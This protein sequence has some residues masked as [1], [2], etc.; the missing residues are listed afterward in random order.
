[1]LD[2]D[3]AFRLPTSCEAGS[4]M[5]IDLIASGAYTSLIAYHDNN[6]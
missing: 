2:D 6:E 1:M 5:G 3:D 4:E